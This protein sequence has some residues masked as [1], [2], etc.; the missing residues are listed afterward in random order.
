MQPVTPTQWVGDQVVPDW[1]PFHNNP[2]A[3]NVRS[4]IFWMDLEQMYDVYILNGNTQTF[5]KHFTTFD[6]ALTLINDTKLTK[7]DDLWT[8]VGN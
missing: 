4:G 1:P 6:D 8:R 5:S 7:I 2:K 3:L